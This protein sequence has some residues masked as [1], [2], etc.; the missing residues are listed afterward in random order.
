[1]PLLALFISY[2]HARKLASSTIK[3][4]LSAISYVQK[5][6]GLRDPTQAFLV[7]LLRTLS[8]QGSCDIR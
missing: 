2:L 8:R 1:M 6:E 5:L 4:Y 7:K 3:S